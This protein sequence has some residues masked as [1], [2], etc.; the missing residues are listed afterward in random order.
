[1][2]KTPLI[3]NDPRNSTFAQIIRKTF[4]AI[5][6][7]SNG[8]LKTIL[9][10]NDNKIQ[11]Q[12][13]MGNEDYIVTLILQREGNHYVVSEFSS[14]EKD[15]DM[16]APYWMPAEWT[17]TLYLEPGKKWI[18][19]KPADIIAL[20]EAHTKWSRFQGFDIAFKGID[21]NI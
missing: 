1:M 2:L 12:A 10:D 14:F 6:Q 16:G 3:S 15:S 5:V 18:I 4:G 8:W 21:K 11:L 13:M 17:L 20:V 19:N 9:G 7:R